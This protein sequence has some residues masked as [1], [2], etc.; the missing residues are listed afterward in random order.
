[1]GLP[2]SISHRFPGHRPCDLPIGGGQ[3]GSHAKNRFCSLASR[4]RTSVAS[5]ACSSFAPF[6]LLS[7]S[8]RD[9]YG[10]VPIVLVC[11]S[12]D[13]WGDCYTT[14]EHIVDPTHGAIMLGRFVSALRH[15]EI[16]GGPIAGSHNF[17][18]GVPLRM[19]EEEF[20]RSL[21]SLHGVIDVAAAGMVWELALQAAEWEGP[22]C[23][24]HGDLHVGNLLARAGELCAVIDFGGLG[25]GDPACDIMVAWTYLS[26]ATRPIF[27]TT[28]GVDEATWTRGRGW[29]L[30]FGVVALPYY[31]SRNP[32]LA[33]I[34][35]R[36]I[37][38][39]LGK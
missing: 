37:E 28:V 38:E 36:A 20:H 24:I 18:R 9:S 12:M 1:M 15:V 6:H 34:A 22:S 27:R 8:S 5:P 13:F 10:R 2:F 16:P 25:M 4:E 11:L 21:A 7:L 3:S 35:R 30:Y 31:Q 19:L 17:F 26:S 29:A 32:M 39:A 33:A 23:W 14:S